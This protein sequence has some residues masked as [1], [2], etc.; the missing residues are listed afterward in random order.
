MKLILYDWNWFYLFIYF[1]FFI[2]WE[3]LINFFM[4]E[5]LGPKFAVF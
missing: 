5:N 4:A 1:L 2:F 3:C